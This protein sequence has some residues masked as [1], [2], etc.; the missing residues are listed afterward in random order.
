MPPHSQSHIP[1]KSKLSWQPSAMTTYN[2]ETQTLPF[3]F[4]EI[5]QVHLVHKSSTIKGLMAPDV[6]VGGHI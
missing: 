3:T 6:G 5:F 1:T 2:G 4:R